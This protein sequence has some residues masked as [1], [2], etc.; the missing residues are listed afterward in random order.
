VEQLQVIL[1]PHNKVTQAALQLAL[2][3]IAAVVEEPVLLAQQHL[4]LAVAMAEQVTI[5]RLQVTP[6]QVVVAV[7]VILLAA[8]AALEVAEQ[9]HLVLHLVA[10]P[11]Q[12]D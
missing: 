7:V 10:H 1:A 3:I 8:Q 2:G 4:Q 12:T 9:D 5:G 6:M 11:A